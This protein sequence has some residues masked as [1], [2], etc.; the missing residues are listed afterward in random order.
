MPKKAVKTL[1]HTK[2][3]EQYLNDV[4]RIVSRILEEALISVFFLSS[5]T[6]LNKQVSITTLC[7]KKVPT[8][9]LSVT[10]SNLSRFSK[11]L[12]CWKAYEICYKTHVT[13]LTSP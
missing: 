6:G 7:L 12:H 11:F 5:A 13:I 2:R 4:G 10:L 3:K 8:F 1:L 9:K